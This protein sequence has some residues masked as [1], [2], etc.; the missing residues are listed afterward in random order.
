MRS[1]NYSTYF[2]SR[3]GLVSCCG[4]R[5]QNTYWFSDGY[6]DYLRSFSWAM[7]SLPELAPKRQ[8]H[9]LGSSSV[10]QSVSYGRDRVAYTTFSPSAQDVL[11]LKFRPTRVA[12][13]AFTAEP[14][15]NGDYIVRVRHDSARRIVVSG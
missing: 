12:G 5:P 1:L 9:L 8:N 14:A 4:L 15:G 7:A 13:G 11:R 3:N 10:V 2:V 6:A